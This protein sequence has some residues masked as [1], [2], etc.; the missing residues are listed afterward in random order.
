M[1]EKVQLILKEG[2]PEYAILPY[3]MYL[4][5]VEDAE[6]LQDI[7]DYDEAIQAIEAGEELVP[8]EIV[9]AI[10]DGENPIK[11]WREYREMTQ[12]QL[13]KKAGISA[14]FLSQIESGKRTGSTDVLKAIAAAL[15][16]TLDDIV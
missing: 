12:A 11:V 5:L 3:D 2:Q 7:K 8:G 9:F 4:Q 6:M 1:K 16:L 10:F 15:D 14:A 13:A